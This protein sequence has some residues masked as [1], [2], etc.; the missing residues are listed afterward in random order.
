[1]QPSKYL[2]L[3]MGKILRPSLEVTRETTTYNWPWV[4][5]EFG[6]YTPTGAS[7]QQFNFFANI[8]LILFH[9]LPP[10]LAAWSHKRWVFH[11]VGPNFEDVTDQCWMA[12]HPDSHIANIAVVG[13][14]QRGSWFWGCY[15]PMLSDFP[16]RFPYCKYCNCKTRN[17]W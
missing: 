6:R 4:N 3:A 11:N 17:V 15:R 2:C 1:M 16:S 7:S 8:N 9:W 14:P 12:S 13:F 5:T 10:H